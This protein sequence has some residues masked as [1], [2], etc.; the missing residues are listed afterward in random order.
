MRE[1]PSLHPAF[2][3]RSGKFVEQHALDNPAQ[4]YVLNLPALIIEEFGIMPLSTDDAVRPAR[5]GAPRPDTAA[6]A[7]IGAPSSPWP[8]LDISL[9]E[10]GRPVLPAFPVDVLPAPWR[11]WVDDAAAEAGAPADYVAQ[12]V[13]A[14]VAGLAGAGVRA[15]VNPG[16]SEPL[17]LWQALVG[18]SSAG[19]TP[20]LETVGR[21]LATVEKLL[22]RDGDRGGKAP[23]IVIRDAAMPRRAAGS[24]GLL[25]WRDQQTPWLQTLQSWV[26][27]DWEQGPFIDSWS[28]RDGLAISLIGSL[29][30]ETLAETLAGTSEGLAARFLFAWPAAPAHRSVCDPRQP[31]EDEAVTLL[32]RIAGIVGFPDKP[33]TLAFDEAALRGFD[34]FLARL[35]DEVRG[36]EG[37]EAAW[38]GK[39]R[40]TV[41]RLAGILAL[42]DWSRS[43]ATTAPVPRAVRLPHLQAAERLWHDYFRPHGRAVLQRALPSD[44]DRQARRVALWL[45]AGAGARPQVTRQE[46]RVQALGKT[47]SAARADLVLGRLWSA[48]LVR[49]ASH[50]PLPQGG[51][52]AHRWDIN[53]ALVG[54]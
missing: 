11:E 48:G 54:T 24:H 2:M 38:L 22:G 44:F 23:A 37:L 39:G 14:A 30:P 27:C 28:V 15:S 9:L 20:A 49:P 33:L 6:S 3:R 12:A 17:V 16:W 34:G 43:S 5:A 51:R 1:H 13:L 7:P 41:A 25:L 40:G 29:H 32:H 47:V 21:P 45:K 36:A 53:P 4:S 46:V 10:D 8:E 19:K 26:D 50:D 35:G 42:L 52:P 31:R 18:A